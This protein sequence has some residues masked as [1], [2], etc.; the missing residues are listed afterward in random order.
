[1][2]DLPLWISISA[3]IL[4]VISGILTLLGSVGLLRLGSLYERMHAPTL[5]TTMG[6]FCVLLAATLVASAMQNRPIFHEFLIT[7]LLIM[8]SPV[9]AILLMQSAIHRDR[10]DN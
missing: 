1:M 4:L 3:S 8:T 6:T 10:A 7:L 2:N 5:G 9:T